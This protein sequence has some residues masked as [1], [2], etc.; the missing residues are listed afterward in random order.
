MS[1]EIKKP[2]EITDAPSPAMELSP[3][4]LKQVSGG[5]SDIFAKL[6]DIKGE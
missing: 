6:G 2:E 3:D 4:E 1:D 5:A